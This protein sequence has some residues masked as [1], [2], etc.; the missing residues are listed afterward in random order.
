VGKGVTFDTGGISIKP[1]SDMWR[2]KGDMAGSAAVLGAML[3]IARLR[4]AVPVTMLVPSALNAVDAHS[5]LPGDVLRAR[6]GKTVMVDNTDAEGRLILMDALYEAGESG[7]THCVDIATLT[8]ACSRALG[9]AVSGLFAND[10]DLA[11]LLTAQGRLYGEE[12]WRLPLVEEYLPMLKNDTAD[13]NNIGNNGTAGAIIAALF[14][15]EFV[16]PGQ[17]WA[18]LDI[19]GTGLPSKP[20]K[21]MPPG[22][23]GVGVRTLAS[24]ARALEV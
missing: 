1:A 21:G 6:N 2:M 16:K 19:A 3:V 15:K 13:L 14:L 4:P 23:T 5:I 12:F 24:L 10:D 8:G 22:A 17:K 11:E 18:H 7:A 20:R 9:P